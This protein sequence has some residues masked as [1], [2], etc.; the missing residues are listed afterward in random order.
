MPPCHLLSTLS[1]LNLRGQNLMQ[2]S[3]YEFEILFSD[4][5]GVTCQD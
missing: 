5:V 4:E 1:T 3:R 2:I